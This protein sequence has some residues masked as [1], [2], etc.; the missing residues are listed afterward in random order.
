MTWTA[1]E[2]TGNSLVVELLVEKGVR[3]LSTSGAGSAIS[4]LRRTSSAFSRLS[5]TS[6]PDASP[7]SS[8]ESFTWKSCLKKS[9]WERDVEG[10]LLTV[11]V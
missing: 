5:V 11:L 9:S 10:E 7:T 4:L 1:E 6:S 8:Q 3:K 2:Q